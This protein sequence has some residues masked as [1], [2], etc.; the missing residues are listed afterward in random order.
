MAYVCYCLQYQNFS[1]F[2]CDVCQKCFCNEEFLKLHI[3]NHLSQDIQHDV[4]GSDDPFFKTILPT[5]I[6]DKYLENCRTTVPVEKKD[7]AS[8][9]C[10]YSDKNGKKCF[11]RFGEK[12]AYDIHVKSH[13]DLNPKRYSFCQVCRK[14]FVNSELPA[15]ILS[16][17]GNSDPATIGSFIRILYS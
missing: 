17:H 3:E 12:E 7:L 8:F 14:K 13:E 11:R 5:D 15:H 10:E 6:N 16:M 1:D 9:E 4:F 2:R